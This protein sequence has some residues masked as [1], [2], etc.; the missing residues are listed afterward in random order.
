M[1]G[2]DQHCQ[3]AECLQKLFVDWIYFDIGKIDEVDIWDVGLIV[4]DYRLTR[5]QEQRPADLC[6]MSQ[7]DAK[8]GIGTS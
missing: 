6:Q 2:I 7:S 8:C 1:D 5:C 3:D 4:E